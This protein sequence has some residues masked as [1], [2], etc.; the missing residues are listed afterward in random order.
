M[1]VEGSAGGL[2]E[3]RWRLLGRSASGC[4]PLLIYKAQKIESPSFCL[5]ANRIRVELVSLV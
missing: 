2:H 1:G 4:P 5:E 3:S